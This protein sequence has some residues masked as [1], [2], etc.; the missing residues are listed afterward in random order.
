[1]RPLLHFPSSAIRPNAL[2]VIQKVLIKRV[3]AQRAGI[4]DDEQLAAGAGHAH[5]HAAD[6]GEEADV[7]GWLERVMRYADD[8]AL[9]ALESS[10]RC[11]R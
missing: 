4:A 6:I 7:A 10:L 5:V 9:L 1:M 11:P 2:H 8:V 3:A